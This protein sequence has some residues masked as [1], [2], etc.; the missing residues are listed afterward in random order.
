MLRKLN[1]LPLLV[2]PLFTAYF[3]FERGIVV[4]PWLQN[5]YDEE[6]LPPVETFEIESR[7]TDTVYAID[8]QVPHRYAESDKRYPVFFVLDGRP[9]IDLYDEMVLPLLRRRAIPEAIFVGINFPPA[10]R[11]GFAE[12]FNEERR[13]AARARPN[14]RTRQLTLHTDERYGPQQSG[15]ADDFLEFLEKELIPEIDERYRTIAGDRGLGG[16]D[17]TGLFVVRAAFAKPGLFRRLI[18]IAPSLHWADYAIIEDFRDALPL[19]AESPSRLYV[20]VG[21]YD[22]QPFVHGWELL[23]DVTVRFDTGSLRVK[24]ELVPVTDHL[25]VI[26]PAAENGLIWVY[27]D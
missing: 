20:A 12:I 9:A 8:V 2:L 4:L 18:A 7:F 10:P 13:A 17:L 22:Y 27:A 16:Y 21:G 25:N 23:R 6:D 1:L 5:R 26:M 14:R 3:V 24:P 19:A 15:D 11:I